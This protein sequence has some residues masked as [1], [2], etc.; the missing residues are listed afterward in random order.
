MSDSFH[1]I[2]SA[3]DRYHLDILLE[4][5]RQNYDYYLSLGCP[6]SVR[7]DIL[8]RVSDAQGDYGRALGY[9]TS[10]FLHDLAGDLDYV[11]AERGTNPSSNPREG[12]VYLAVWDGK[13]NLFKIGKSINPIDR[14]E[15][16]GVK[17]P[18]PLRS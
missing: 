6:E 16:I 8:N 7:L 9:E 2:E 11:L 1:V 13:D 17:L 3:L 12:Y 14:I 18:Q 10:R 5:I 15:S 4:D